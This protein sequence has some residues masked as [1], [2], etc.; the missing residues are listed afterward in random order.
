MPQAQRSIVVDV[1]PEQFIE[2]VKDFEKYPEFLPEVSRLTVT[3]RT[4]SSAEVH[5]EIEVI[6]RI[7]YTLRMDWEGSNGNYKVAW[8]LLSSDLLKKNEGSWVLRP[9]GEG[10][11]HATYSLD[12]QIGGFIPVP[13]AITNKLAE[14]SL[15]A[16]LNNFKNRAESVAGK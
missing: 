13:A 16:L 3:N 4:A 2:V 5:Y 15:P 12:L 8:R 10:K 1:P 9:E 6:K 14:Q 11:T 7:K